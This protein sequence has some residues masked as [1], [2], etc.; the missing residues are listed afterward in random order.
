MKLFDIGQGT[1]VGGGPAYPYLILKKTAAEGQESGEM[2]VYKLPNEARG[3]EQVSFLT[4]KL[5]VGYLSEGIFNLVDLGQQSKNR[6]QL[7]LQ[8]RIPGAL[9]KRFA[10]DH[11]MNALAL[12]STNGN[13]FLYNLPAAI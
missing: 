9:I 1:I 13:V 12:T 11:P 6:L 3:I 4:D 5:L 8:I 7:A 2:T 10:V